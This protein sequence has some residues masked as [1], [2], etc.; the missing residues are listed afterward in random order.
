MGNNTSARKIYFFVFSWKSVKCAMTNNLVKD[1]FLF[2]LLVVQK[3]FALGG[4]CGYEIMFLWT[5]DCAVIS[6]C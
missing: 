3:E 4:G 1:M 6:Q 5:E 2:V